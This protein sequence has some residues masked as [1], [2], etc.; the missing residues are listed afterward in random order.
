MPTKFEEF[1]ESLIGFIDKELDRDADRAIGGAETFTN[2][3]YRWILDIQNVI[4]S[5]Y[6]DYRRIGK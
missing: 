2:S 3:E 1:V 5:K 4:D 6:R